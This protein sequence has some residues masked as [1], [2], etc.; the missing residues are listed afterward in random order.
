MLETY[1]YHTFIYTNSYT[2][3]WDLQLGFLKMN[4][5]THF[6]NFNC[7]L[8]HIRKPQSICSEHMSMMQ[9]SI[10]DI[11]DGDPYTFIAQQIAI[12]FFCVF[13]VLDSELSR[14]IWIYALKI[15]L[16][17]RLS[18]IVAAAVVSSTK[19]AQAV[20]FSYQIVYVLWRYQLRLLYYSLLERVYDC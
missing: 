14:Y 18:F 12:S 20:F 3:I 5:R 19:L 17:F 13:I 7:Y 15:Y 6:E 11:D 1:H 16:V 8:Q 10:L 4:F 9:H 2:S